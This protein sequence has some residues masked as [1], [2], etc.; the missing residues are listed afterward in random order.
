M[1]EEPTRCAAASLAIDEPLHGTAPRASAWLLVEHSGPWGAKALT[2]SA[3]DPEL[4]GELERRAKDAG[5]KVLLVKRPGRRAGAEDRRAFVCSPHRAAPF[6]EELELTDP[7][8]LLAV[9]LAAVARGEPTGLGRVRA[10]P[11]YLVCTNG[12]RDACCARLGVPVLRAFE[13]VR[14]GV[15][16]E[17]SHIGGHRYAANV[18]YLPDG[19]CYGRITPEDVPDLVRGHEDGRL[20]IAHLRGRASL[21]PPEQAAESFLRLREGI[22]AAQGL[23]LLRSSNGSSTFETNDGRRFRVEVLLTQGPERP[24]SCGEAPEPSERFDLVSV[25]ELERRS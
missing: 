2:E 22:V 15:A 20:G 7:A 4:G 3:L 25:L 13:A 21:T 18:V 17:C 23:S 16:W 19:L 9:D 11:L 10:E 6:V 14:P 5:A 1:A 12:R 8:A 24:A